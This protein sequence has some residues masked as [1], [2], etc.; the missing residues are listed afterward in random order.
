MYFFEKKATCDHGFFPNLFLE[1]PVLGFSRAISGHS[2]AKVLGPNKPY[3]TSVGVNMV[4]KPYFPQYDQPQNSYLMFIVHH[5]DGSPVLPWWP[6][7]GMYPK[8]R[9]GFPS[10]EASQ[11]ISVVPCDSCCLA[12]TNHFGEYP[13]AGLMQGVEMGEK[14]ALVNQALGH[15]FQITL[16]SQD[17]MIEISIGLSVRVGIDRNACEEANAILLEPGAFA[18][19]QLDGKHVHI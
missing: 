7:K 18:I 1:E 10:T 17:M 11:R 12:P 15:N 3:E 6:T 13:A 14:S 2:P 9:S 16:K 4:Y 5:D 8:C 19:V